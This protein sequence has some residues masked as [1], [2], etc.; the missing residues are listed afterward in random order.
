M[1]IKH[2][3][4][5][6]V[7]FFSV[8]L[9]AG[10]SGANTAASSVTP[11]AWA[12]SLGQGDAEYDGKCAAFV[13]QAWAASGHDLAEFDPGGDHFDLN[14]AREAGY[15]YRDEGRLIADCSHI[16]SGAPVF[17]FDSGTPEG[18]CA[19]SLGFGDANGSAYVVTTGGPGVR[20][21]TLAYMESWMGPCAGW[22][23]VNL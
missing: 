13:W 22:G 20:V 6:C 7:V 1:P 9:L 10:C 18:H 23:N 17:W 4:Y 15:R 3:L 14:T 5:F 2:Q 21:R 16:P 12:L 8:L 11:V 19:L